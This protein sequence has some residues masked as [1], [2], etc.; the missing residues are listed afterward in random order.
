MNSDCWNTLCAYALSFFSRFPMFRCRELPFRLEA[1]RA[2]GCDTTSTSCRMNSASTL[3]LSRFS[4]RSR[5]SFVASSC[6]AFGSLKVCISSIICCC[7]SARD[8][9]STAIFSLSVSIF[10]SSFLRFFRSA[11]A[12]ARVSWESSV[13]FSLKVS[14]CF[15]LLMSSVLPAFRL[16]SHA[17]PLLIW[18][19][20]A[21]IMV[22]FALISFRVSFLDLGKSL[23]NAVIWSSRSYSFSYFLP[24]S[25]I[26]RAWSMSL[27]TLSTLSSICWT[28]AFAFFINFFRLEISEFVFLNF[29]L[30][31]SFISSGDMFVCVSS[32]ISASSFLRASRRFCRCKPLSWRL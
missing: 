12:R 13:C 14:S 24:F 29:F 31:L 27:R 28:S 9:S 19:I 26:T 7:F 3:V 16:P 30:S 8:R 21:T 32:T 11:L 23:M 4:V 2:R 20:K 15:T 1:W 18:F 17:T 25:F 5:L 10:F 6:R 22:C